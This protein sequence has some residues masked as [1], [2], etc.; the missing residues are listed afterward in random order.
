M[1][2]R[3][4]RREHLTAAEKAYFLA[5]TEQFRRDLLPLFASLKAFGEGY[6]ALY[7]ITVAIDEAGGALDL[8]RPDP[9]H[10]R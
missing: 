3:L 8:E 5:K 2:K 4:K 9:I 7:A 10:K 6:K 1:T